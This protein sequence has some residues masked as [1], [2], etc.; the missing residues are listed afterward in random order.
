MVERYV[1]Y[2]AGNIQFYCKVFIPF[3]QCVTNVVTCDNQIGQRNLSCGRVN[4]N[5]GCY[6][7]ESSFFQAF[8]VTHVY[9]TIGTAVN[10]VA[11]SFCNIQHI[12]CTVFC[13][14][15]SCMCFGINHS[16]THSYAEFRRSYRSRPAN[17]V[18]SF[19]C[20]SCVLISFCLIVA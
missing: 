20:F 15:T 9:S 8:H 6:A 18:A 1:D 3:Q 7:C 10:V 12:H 5:F 17:Q 16:D 11:F 13:T 14:D 4:Q 19:F 2:D